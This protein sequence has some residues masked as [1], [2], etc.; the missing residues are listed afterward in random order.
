[1]QLVHFVNSILLLNHLNRVA[2]IAAGVSSCAYIF[3]SSDASAPGGI[4]VAA[5]FGNTSQKM[6]EFI[7]QDA[8][9]TTSNS[10]VDSGSAASLLSGALSLALCCILWFEFLH[11]CLSY[12]VVALLNMEVFR[13]TEN[14]PIWDPT[15][16]AS[17]E[18][19]VLIYRFHACNCFLF[20]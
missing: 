15:S 12:L 5:T 9:A 13:Y 16:P 17:G 11:I 19:V 2:V 4:G 20:L 14:L 18:Y 10:S 3:D 8:H 6:E 7:S 1:V